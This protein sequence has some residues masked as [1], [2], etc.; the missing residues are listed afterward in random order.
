M[1]EII[2]KWWKQANRDILAAKN[3]VDSGDYYASVFFSEQAIE[4]G[5]SNRARITCTVKAVFLKTTSTQ[6][7]S[8]QN[9]Q[10]LRS[11]CPLWFNPENNLKNIS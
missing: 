8:P 1:N 5:L 4:K 10:S 6:L 3:C 7:V 2:L 9:L 11:R